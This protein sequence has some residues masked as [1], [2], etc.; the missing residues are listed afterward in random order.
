MQATIMWTVYGEGHM[1]ENCG[2]PL[3]P[4]DLSPIKAMKWI[5]PKPSKFG[6]RHWTPKENAF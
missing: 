1:D 6:K 3:G 4:V 2:K 5:W